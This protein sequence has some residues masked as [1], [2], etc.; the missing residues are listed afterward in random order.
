MINNESIFNLL[1]H[2]IPCLGKHQPVG[3]TAFQSGTSERRVKMERKDG[4][5]KWEEK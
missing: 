3:E 4:E 5:G 2:N 1:Q